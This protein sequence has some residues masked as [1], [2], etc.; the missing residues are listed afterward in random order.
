MIKVN[1]KTTK[2]PRFPDGTLHIVADSE[3]VESQKLHTVIS[4]YYEN[5]D[6]MAALLF[7]TKHFKGLGF[8]VVLFMPY[9]PNARMDRAKEET[10]ILTLKHFADFINSLD[11][12]FVIVID[13]HSAVSAALLNNLVVIQPQEYID[14]A[15]T[16]IYEETNNN[17]L[18][19]FYPDEGAMKRYSEM[20]DFPYAFGVKKRDWVTGKI[21][22]LNV[23][24]DEDVLY[25]K[26]V[27]IIDDISSKGGTF[28]HSAK[29]L[30]EIGVKK[31]Y[32]YVTHC[33]KTILE[34]EIFSS[35]LIEK[36]FTTNSIFT[37]TAQELAKSK[38]V[39]DK[40]EVMGVE[41]QCDVFN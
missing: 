22:G 28:Y 6:E 27:L 40:I 17:P 8:E 35:G 4:W 5:D 39:A 12:S 31:I 14:K 34:G 32:L 33:E 24:G 25:G 21:L 19:L 16:T 13:P 7:L 3:D 20:I 38:G 37:S 26:N 1:G 41:N 10:D 36:V 2:L 30:K 15:I 29:K 11:F 23:I 9:I 18:M